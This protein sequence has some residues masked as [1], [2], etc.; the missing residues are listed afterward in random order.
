[1]RVRAPWP[2]LA[3]WMFAAGCVSTPELR[4]PA[5]ATT[6]RTGA[7]LAEGE[8]VRLIAR[9]DRWKGNPTNLPSIVT[10]VL[11]QLENKSA[12]PLRIDYAD[13]VLVGGSS[14]EYAALSPFQLREEGQSAVG[15]S[16][17]EGS[18]APSGPVVVTPARWG[19]FGHGWHVWGPGWYG[20]GWYDPFYGPYAY[21]YGY[22]YPPPEPLP[23]QDMTRA[24][25]PKGTLA[26]G[27][28]LSGFLYFQNVV[29]REGQVTLQAKL[30]DAT[31]GE[32]FGTLSIPFDVRS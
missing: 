10:P 20:P 23:T 16:G 27:G 29:Q 5:T 31:T 11:V 21:G 18:V 14:F 17:F 32:S 15:G 30:V 3:A 12:H 22:G 28:T 4:P 13:F 25:L 26:P 19:H 1:M 7:P 8:G 24:A 9:G 6:T 2:L